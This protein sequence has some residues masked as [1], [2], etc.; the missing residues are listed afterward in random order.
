MDDWNNEHST[1]FRCEVAW[2][3]NGTRHETRR[4]CSY[5]SR[6]R[7]RSE[8]RRAA[9]AKDH[10]RSSEEA[11][12]QR[13]AQRRPARRVPHEAFATKA[14]HI[15]YIVR[16][17]RRRFFWLTPRKFSPVFVYPPIKKWDLGM[18]PGR[19][20]YPGGMCL[21]VPDR[22]PR[23]KSP[24]AACTDATKASPRGLHSGDSTYSPD[25]CRGGVCGCY[26]RIAKV[27]RDIHYV[28]SLCAQK[29]A[30]AMAQSLPPA[31][32]E[33]SNADRSCDHP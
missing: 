17:A 5:L 23:I 19:T 21:P 14:D 28:Q 26:V 24:P 8:Q 11:R 25:I 12:R 27:A 33:W 7:R 16:A 29:K 18:I 4:A 10:R 1:L 32:A 31:L 15:I 3:E 20:T 30:H 13:G 22:V 9:G 2:K 6:F